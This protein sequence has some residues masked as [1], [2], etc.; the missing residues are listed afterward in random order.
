[1]DLLILESEWGRNNMNLEDLNLTDDKFKLVD[2]S[3]TIH[4]MELA[5]KPIGYFKDAFNRFK[6]NKASLV[7]AVIIG[8]LVL[9]AIFAPIF[10]PYSVSYADSNYSYAL[11]RNSLFVKFGWNFW[12]GCTDAKVTKEDFYYELSK[13][14]ETGHNSIKNNKYT[15][16]EELNPRKQVVTYYK[17]RLDTYQQVG[18]IFLNVSAEEYANIQKYQDETGIQVIYPVTD[19][20]QRPVSVQDN[21]NGGYWFKTTDIPEGSTSSDGKTHIVLD[22]NGDFINIYLPYSDKDNY[23]SKMRIEGENEYLYSYG[24]PNAT[25]YEIRINYY[26]Y[27]VYNHTYVL[28]DG[29]KTP[30]YLFGA[31]HSGQDIWTCLAS[32][33]RFSFILAIL[34]AVVNLVVGAIYGAIEGYYGGKID[35]FMER[36]VDILSA[37]PFMIV[38]TLLKY[39]MEGSSPVLILFIAFFLTGWIGMASR[40][41]MQFYRF[42]NQEY[43]LAARTLG[44]SDKR[45][46]FKHI[47]PN[48]LG[49]LITGC[50]LVIPSMIFSETSLSYLGIINLN[51][52]RMTS[53]GTL[54][55]NAQ[56]YLATYPHMVLFPALFISMLMLSFNLFGNGLR[57]AFNPSLRGSED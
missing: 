48:A 52:G 32:G 21:S 33:A 39:H 43:V 28:K 3:E 45:I 8:I 20:N 40:T 36:F 16:V 17:Y 5:T 44:A 30:S 37:V 4:D 38:I 47:F 1:M 12:D 27:Y 26:E 24:I 6:K 13:G 22:E 55:A 7:A 51:N 10:S 35:L 46:M 41:R 49:T 11:P 18:V 54:L 2:R 34:V 42:K 9:Y 14:V 29:I 53:V 15:I 31:T 19:P 50:V 25:G 23:T 57:D 56:P